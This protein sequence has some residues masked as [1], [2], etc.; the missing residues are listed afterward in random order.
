MRLFGLL[1]ECAA[2][3]VEPELLN[4]V[5]DGARPFTSEREA[6][7]RSSRAQRYRSKAQG[8]CFRRWRSG[9]RARGRAQGHGLRRRAEYAMIPQEAEVQRRTAR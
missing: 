3:R 2:E 5:Q 9:N 4:A 7:I 6:S 8:S 1:Q